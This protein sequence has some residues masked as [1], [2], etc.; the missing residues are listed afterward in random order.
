MQVRAALGEL[1]AP[2]REVLVL[3]FYHDLTIEETA[4]VMG[5]SVGRVRVHYDG[6]KRHL[7]ER[8]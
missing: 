5:V 3:V 1:P 6:A 8:L 4:Q 2:Q 7:A